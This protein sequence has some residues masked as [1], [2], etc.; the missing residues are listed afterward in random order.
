MEFLNIIV[1]ILIVFPCSRLRPIERRVCASCT[2][3]FFLVAHKKLY[4]SLTHTLPIQFKGPFGLRNRLKHDKGLSRV[5]SISVMYNFNSIFTHLKLLKKLLNLQL[6]GIVWKAPA[7][8]DPK[9]VDLVKILS[10]FET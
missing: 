9:L 6:P 1:V 2:V 8:Q 3:H 7:F 4:I 10:F 5:F